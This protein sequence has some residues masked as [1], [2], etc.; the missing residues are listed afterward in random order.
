MGLNQ[1][2]NFIQ[3]LV[4]MVCFQDSPCLAFVLLSCFP[5]LF[6]LLPKYPHFLFTVLH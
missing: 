3:C 5:K 2:L 4:F 6:N 1:F